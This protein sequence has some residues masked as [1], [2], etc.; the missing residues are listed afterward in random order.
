MKKLILV[1]ALLSLPAIAADDPN[2]KDPSARYLS[3]NHKVNEILV[4]HRIV[5][6]V[7]AACNAERVRLGK[8]P[9]PY[10][11]DACTFWSHKVTGNQCTIITGPTTSQVELGHELRHCLQGSFH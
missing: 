2:W 6:D 3:S 9:F 5:K 10:S 1:F 4:K 8:K 7:N 11:V